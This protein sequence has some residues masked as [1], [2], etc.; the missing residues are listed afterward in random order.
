[1]ILIKNIKIVDGSGQPAYP[2]DI[3]ITGSKIS[4]I[5]HFPNKKAELVVEGLGHYLAPGFIDVYSTIDH[6][7]AI[8][9][10]T[11]QEKVWR[12]GITTAI[13]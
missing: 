8:F 11:E 4:A 1:M 9:D 7:L 6:D 13:G 5:G 12:E 10:K 3:L 2:G